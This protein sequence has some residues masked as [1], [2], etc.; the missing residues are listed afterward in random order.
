MFNTCEFCGESLY[1]E[2][3]IVPY[4]D[5]FA[6]A[7]AWECHNPDCSGEHAPKCGA[8]FKEG[9]LFLD[10]HSGELLCLDEISCGKRSRRLQVPAEIQE[11]TVAV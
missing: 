7:G 8:C 10:G 5:T 9:N 4:G 6:D 3:N 11:W 1:W 2:S